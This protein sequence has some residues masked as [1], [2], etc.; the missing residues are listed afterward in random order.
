[1]PGNWVSGF[2]RLAWNVFTV[3]LELGPSFCPKSAVP[4]TH[5]HSHFVKAAAG[6][7]PQ[8]GND[9]PKRAETM[10]PNQ[11]PSAYFY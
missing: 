4:T 6:P 9:S 3:E 10:V 5:S 8:M 7:L 11:L 2:L 1:M